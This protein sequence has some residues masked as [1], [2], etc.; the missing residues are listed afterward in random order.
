MAHSYGLSYIVDVATAIGR[1]TVSET[2]ALKMSTSCVNFT[3]LRFTT[4]DAMQRYLADVETIWTPAVMEELAGLGLLRKSITRIWNHADQYKLGIL[5]EYTSPAAYQ[6]CQ[7]I[8]AKRI[9]PTAHRYEMVAR[10]L[11]GV[12]IMDWRSDDASGLTV[13]GNLVQDKDQS[14]YLADSDNGNDNETH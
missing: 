9:L 12:P 13:E 8:I 3:E 14:H 5:W 7:K 6:K 2:L 1:I 4:E 11:R 10:A